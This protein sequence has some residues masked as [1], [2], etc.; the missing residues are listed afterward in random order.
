MNELNTKLQKRGQY[1]HEMFAQTKAFQGKL[2]LLKCQTKRHNLT[3]FTTVHELCADNELSGK[4]TEYAAELQKLTDEFE[5]RFCD[6]QK[7]DLAMRIFA[8]PISVDVDDVPPAL[9][10]ELIELQSSDALRKKFGE[11]GLKEF[12]PHI[13]HDCPNLKMYATKN[14]SLRINV[15]LRTVLFESEL[16]EISFSNTDSRYQS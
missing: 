13:K 6:F 9:Q 14:G 5:R 16:H 15:Y 4:D 8:T 7:Q 2:K 1:A 3:H 12:Y 11:L 10:M